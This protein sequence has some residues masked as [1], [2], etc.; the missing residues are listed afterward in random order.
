MERNRNSGKSQQRGEH[1]RARG[2]S[3][4][5]W[6]RCDGATVSTWHLPSSV[7]RSRARTALRAETAPQNYFG[8]LYKELAEKVS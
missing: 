8:F 4:A 5:R 3:E 2:G 6:C 1:E 7:W